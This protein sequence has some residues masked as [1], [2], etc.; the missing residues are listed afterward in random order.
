M[1]NK[2]EQRGH[3]EIEEW[4]VEADNSHRVYLYCADMVE[5][6]Q[7]ERKAINLLGCLGRARCSLPEHQD[8]TMRFMGRSDLNLRRSPLN[9]IR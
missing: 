4:D 8:G 5:Y 6:M 7:R 3:G 1:S 9:D 2:S